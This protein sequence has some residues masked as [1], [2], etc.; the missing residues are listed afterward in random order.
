MRWLS[1]IKLR[2]RSLFDRDAVER[3]LDAELRFH[4]EQQI[5]E[6]IAAGMSAG[7]AQVAALRRLGG[8]SQITEECRDA[9]GV[10]WLEEFAQDCRYG[11]R[12]LRKASGFT[13]VA[14]LTLG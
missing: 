2:I 12:Q 10:S 3:E 5:A 11:G 6:N 9:R 14:V 1:K 4:L 8:I 7:D 13:A